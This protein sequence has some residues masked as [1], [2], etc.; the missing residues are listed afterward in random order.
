MI[1]HLKS[2]SSEPSLEVIRRRELQGQQVQQVTCGDGG[3]VA[4]KHGE[5]D[6]GKWWLDLCNCSVVILV[7]A[8]GMV[9]IVQ[10]SVICR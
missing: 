10:T 5:H 6:T 1:H 8:K 2:R 4:E 9:N 3:L 7:S